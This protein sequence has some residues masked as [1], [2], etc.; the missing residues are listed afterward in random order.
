MQKI[1]QVRNTYSVPGRWLVRSSSKLGLSD[2]FEMEQAV[3]GR[4]P[5]SILLVSGGSETQVWFE[6]LWLFSVVLHNIVFFSNFVL[7]LGNLNIYIVSKR[8]RSNYHDLFLHVNSMSPE[9]ERG[10]W[11]KICQG[12]YYTEKSGKISHFLTL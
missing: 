2:D 10:D 12:Y 1:C 6:T 5:A 3:V 4:W 7:R 11:A 8:D 9:L